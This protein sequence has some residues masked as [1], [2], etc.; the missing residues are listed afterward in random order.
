MQGYPDRPRP[1]QVTLYAGLC[2]GGPFHGRQL[3]HGTPRLEVARDRISFKIVGWIGGET[4]G[5]M[6]DHYAH[7]SGRWTWKEK[8][9]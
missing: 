5:I 7:E 3:Y 6:V 1:G 2:E 9:R 4:G 8:K